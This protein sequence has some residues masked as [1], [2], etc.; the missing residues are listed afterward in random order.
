M[1]PK[2]IIL[3]MIIITAAMCGVVVAIFPVQGIRPGNEEINYNEHCGQ[4]LHACHL[5]ITSLGGCAQIHY[6]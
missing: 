2:K 6:S 5:Q 3:I 1:F 4:A